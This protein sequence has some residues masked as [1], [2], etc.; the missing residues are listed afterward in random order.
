LLWLCVKISI[1]R[2]GKM[3]KDIIKWE[4][5]VGSES[6][7][8]ILLVH[9]TAPMNIDGNIPMCGYDYP[10]GSMSI[11]KKLSVEKRFC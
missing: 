7:G 2:R 11:Y 6:R 1:D 9:G 10:L 4:H 5:P 8:S 3:K